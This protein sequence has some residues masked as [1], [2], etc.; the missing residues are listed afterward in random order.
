MMA[1]AKDKRREELQKAILRLTN[2][3]LPVTISAVAREVGVTPALIHNTYSDVAEQIRAL[4]GKGLRAQRD[5]LREELAKLR[6]SNQ[7]LRQEKEKAD[8]D[9]RMLASMLEAMRHEMARL[10]ARAE[11]KVVE[12]GK[13]S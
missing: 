9:A 13:I 7:T 8:A 2:R 11:G 6:A 1:S 10:K 12:M 3:K 5:E 4:Q